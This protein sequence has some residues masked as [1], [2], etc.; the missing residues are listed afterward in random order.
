MVTKNSERELL[1][2]ILLTIRQAG[3]TFRGHRVIESPRDPAEVRR[4]VE[5]R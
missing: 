5:T 1:N 2:R 3:V 4:K